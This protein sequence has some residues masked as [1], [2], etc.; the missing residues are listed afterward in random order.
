MKLTF[1]FAVLVL[2]F[3]TSAAKS[4]EIDKKVWT[5][6]DKIKWPSKNKSILTFVSREDVVYNSNC[7]ELVD[8]VD[9]FYDNTDNDSF[10]FGIF[11]GFP[12]VTFDFTKYQ[13]IG[14]QHIEY[15]F[16]HE[17]FHLV[18]QGLGMKRPINR[19]GYDAP[20]SRAQANKLFKL[21]VENSLEGEHSCEEYQSLYRGYSQK[22]LDYIYF[23]AFTEWPA[24]FYAFHRV[25]FTIDEYM[26]LTHKSSRKAEFLKKSQ[27]K[28]FDENKVRYQSGVLIIT[29]LEK[30]ISREE[31]QTR[32][33]VDGA[34]PL[35]QF[36]D[37]LGCNISE[38]IIPIFVELEHKD[39]TQ[40]I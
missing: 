20:K 29:E 28:S 22:E 40:G 32:L 27:I 33:A 12:V 35:S 6:S 16:H 2:S 37:V 9:S 7:D 39:L 36:F 34:S 21:L 19:L 3:S 8:I 24:E 23:T 5:L 25:A 18:V 14:K 15:L 17:S 31:W 11:C 30:H 38:E 13:N 26:N 1:L 4:I 10:F